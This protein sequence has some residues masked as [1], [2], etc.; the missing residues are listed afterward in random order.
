MCQN[1]IKSLYQVVLGNANLMVLLSLSDLL[2]GDDY[3]PP[4]EWPKIGQ[5]TK[6]IALVFSILEHV[7]ESN[8]ITVSGSTWKGESS[9]ITYAIPAREEGK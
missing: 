4:L 1:R 2:A 6:A 9:G 7:S 5:N 3:R 8:E